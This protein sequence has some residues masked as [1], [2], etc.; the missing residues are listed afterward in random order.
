MFLFVGVHSPRK[1]AATYVGSIPG[2]GSLIMIALRGGWKVLGIMGTY[3]HSTDGGDEYVSCL[4]S[5][6]NPNSAEFTI[7]PPH[8]MP[9]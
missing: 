5:F 6:L 3:V 9:H 7:L 4:L 1:S 8:L 2:G